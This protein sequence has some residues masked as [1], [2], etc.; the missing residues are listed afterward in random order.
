MIKEI[1]S[2]QNSLIIQ[3]KKLK[4]KKN[5]EISDSFVVE[6]YR[7]VLDSIKFS[8][9]LH[10]FVTEMQNFAFPCPVY[11]V[12]EKIFEEISDTKTPQGVLG[13]F[14]IPISDTENISDRIVLLNGVSDPGNI[15]TI[16]RTSVATGFKTVILD[17]NCADV[18]S[19]KVVR[20]AMSAVF[21][22]NILRVEGL[23]GIFLK[24]SDYT[25]YAS[26]LSDNQKNLFDIKF[27]EKTALIFGSEANGI[28]P[29]ILTKSD[30]IFKIPMEEGIES[31]NVS[32]AAAVSQYEVF[33][34]IPK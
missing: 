9:P 12:P 25:F 7:N 31:L 16:L 19:G 23:D 8:K 6:G 2:R 15:G 33:R 4:T 34:Q 1:T 3:V 14:S 28:E 29:E 24:Y 11:K 26:A 22:L 27:N 20:S 10:V 32:V 5:R 30:V 13:V 18:F 17:K 21:S